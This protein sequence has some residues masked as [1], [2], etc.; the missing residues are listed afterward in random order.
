MGQPDSKAQRI[1]DL[2]KQGKK[3]KEIHIITGFSLKYI[4]NIR[5]EMN[6]PGIL[7]KRHK[8]WLKKN[9]NYKNKL[10]KKNPENRSKHRKNNITKHMKATRPHAINY[11]QEWTTKDIKYLEQNGQ[12]KTIRQL[13]LDLGRTYG[14]ILNAGHRYKI[15]L[16]GIKTKTPSSRVS[17]QPTQPTLVSPPILTT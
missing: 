1:R 5:D 10:R 3:T 17:P 14:A 6:N 9:P 8:L 7:Q 4:W 13:A 15:D 11:R 2:F 16:R 12:S